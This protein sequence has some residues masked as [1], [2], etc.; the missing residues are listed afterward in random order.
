[1]FDEVKMDAIAKLEERRGAA[2]E[3]MDNME[4]MIDI[5]ETFTNLCDDVAA[6]L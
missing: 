6:D 2:P 1:V 3:V 5:T 4:M